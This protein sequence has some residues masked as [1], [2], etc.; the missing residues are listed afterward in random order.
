MNGKEFFFH[1]EVFN[2]HFYSKDFNDFRF[3]TPS[4][5]RTLRSAFQRAEE[6]LQEESA[7]YIPEVIDLTSEE[8]DN[9]QV[10]VI[11]LTNNLTICLSVPI[12]I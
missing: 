9:F 4:G 11:D 7:R 1:C 10:E 8:E 12:S 3:N 2:H 5:E 6:Q